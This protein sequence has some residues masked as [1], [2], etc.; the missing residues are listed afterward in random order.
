MSS[1][2]S[3][4][5]KFFYSSPCSHNMYLWS[6]IDRFAWTFFGPSNH[7]HGMSCDIVISF[8][9]CVLMYIC[10]ALLKLFSKHVEPWHLLER[11][12][13][14]RFSM[15][16]TYLPFVSHVNLKCWLARDM[17]QST[18]FPIFFW[19]V[20]WSFCVKV[21]TSFFRALFLT[22]FFLNF[23]KTISETFSSVY[24]EVYSLLSPDLYKDV[25]LANQ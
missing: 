14:V 5:I 23:F 2:R 12:E 16:V 22:V 24:I 13:T 7:W 11:W 10:L 25:R 17:G 8:T 21:C 4:D 6:D 1:P 19:F 20:N 15:L 9:L 18:S 3:A